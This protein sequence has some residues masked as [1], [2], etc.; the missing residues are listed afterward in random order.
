M[1]LASLFACLCCFASAPAWAGPQLLLTES[2]RVG[3]TDKK[4][5][6]LLARLEAALVKAGL[7]LERVKS[8]CQGE[9]PCLVTQAKA[10]GREA[11]VSVSLVMSLKSVIVDLEAVS[12][13]TGTVLAQANFKVKPAE[14]A[15]PESVN[16]FAHSIEE[17]LEVERRAALEAKRV[18]D[19][20]L[21]VELVPPPTTPLA[22]VLVP[23][24]SPSRAPVV[25]TAVAAGAALIASAVLVGVAVSTQAQLPPRDSTRDPLPLDRAQQ[26]VQD[27][28]TAWTGALVA[29]SAAGALGLT[30]LIL[31][32]TTK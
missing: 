10:A 15:L 1:K 8:E 26:L 4:A 17:Q 23:A 25:I 19:A 30:A 7:S 6:E 32:V 31:G 13:A 28:N 12:A 24:A 20:P 29:G 27:A 22:V 21:K 5:S 2:S 3:L 9:R 16:A 18:P 11:M 14:T